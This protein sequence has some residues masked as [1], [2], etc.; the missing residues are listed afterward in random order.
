MWLWTGSKT[1]KR[2]AE[3]SV[4]EYLAMQQQAGRRKAQQRKIR[5]P[6]ERVIS[7]FFAG[8]CTERGRPVKALRYAPTATRRKERGLD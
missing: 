4:A 2:G 6:R 5:R 3:P 1:T 8:E 7:H